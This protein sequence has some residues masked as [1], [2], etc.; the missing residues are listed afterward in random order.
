[1]TGGTGAKATRGDG[2][3]RKGG[4]RAVKRERNWRAKHGPG[5]LGPGEGIDLYSGDEPGVTWRGMKVNGRKPARE[6][7]RRGGKANDGPR[8]RDV[9]WKRPTRTLPPR[10]WPF[11]AWWGMGVGTRRERSAPALATDSSSSPLF[12]PVARLFARIHPPRSSASPARPLPASHSFSAAC[13]LLNYPPSPS[14][15]AR[16]LSCVAVRLGRKGRENAH[17]ASTPPADRESPFFSPS[18]STH[19]LSPHPP[20]FGGALPSD[21][22][23]FPLARSRARVPP[24]HALLHAG[25]ALKPRALSPSSSLSTLF[26]LLVTLPHRREPPLRLSCVA[27]L[28]RGSS[29]GRRE[30]SA[31]HHARGGMTER[32]SRWTVTGRGRRKGG[33][34]GANG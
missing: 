33:G 26:C 11:Q 13:A 28:D 17:V 23:P 8:R 31:G 7:G 27:A 32:R 12:L 20:C 18:V 5:R 3:K 6:E 15:P 4:R 10:Q 21:T 2:H 29:R 34:G 1:M 14:L 24:C 9:L 30:E 25:T 19:S 22:I 16:G